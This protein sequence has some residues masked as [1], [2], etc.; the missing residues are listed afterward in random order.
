MGG[1]QEYRLG[2]CVLDLEKLNREEEGLLMDRCQG[3]FP[4]VNTCEDARLDLWEGN[5]PVAFH[6]PL[7]E[8]L[9]GGPTDR[10][11][12]ALQRRVVNG[13]PTANQVSFAQLDTTA[14]MKSAEP[15]KKE[16]KP[17]RK[18]KKQMKKQIKKMWANS[19][20]KK[21]NFKESKGLLKRTKR[22]LTSKG[23]LKRNM[24]KEQHKALKK[25]AQ[26]SN[27]EEKRDLKAEKKKQKTESMLEKWLALP[28]TPAKAKAIDKYLM[29][30]PQ[31]AIKEIGE[32]MHERAKAK[33]A[34][35]Y[36]KVAEYLKDTSAE[37]LELEGDVE[38]FLENVKKSKKN[39]APIS[40][41]EFADT[42]EISAEEL[43]E[44]RKKIEKLQNFTK[45]KKLLAQARTQEKK[46]KKSAVKADLE[47][48]FTPLGPKTAARE[49][50]LRKQAEETAE[51]KKRRRR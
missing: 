51:K 36:K 49:K 35:Q 31:I 1:K 11:V 4:G 9:E 29:E 16:T 18:E 28:N 46:E 33:E 2:D 27:K 6:D 32:I 12:E 40:V 20:L 26:K 25:E 30:Y 22:L 13:P 48:D 24:H 34:A 43:A 23:L 44:G 38:K 10:P 37:R 17:T 21:R 14:M 3:M 45:T 19:K 8:V 47:D 42:M 15:T 39:E 5:V 7:C 41:E 50:Q